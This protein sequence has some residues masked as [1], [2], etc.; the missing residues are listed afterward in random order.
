MCA[1]NL[2]IDEIMTFTSY[3]KFGVPLGEGLAVRGT[4]GVVYNIDEDTGEAGPHPF[5]EGRHCADPNNKENCSEPQFVD[6]MTY[7]MAIGVNGQIP[8]PTL[9]VHENQTVIIHVHNNLSTEGG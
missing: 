2:E 1:M 7:R 8:G 3:R 4:Q 5:Y 6:G 9:I